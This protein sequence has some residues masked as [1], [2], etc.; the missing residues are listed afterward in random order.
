MQLDARCSSF[1]TANLNY[2][3]KWQNSFSRLLLF[4]VRSRQ[5]KSYGRFLDFFDK[6]RDALAA[7]DT[8]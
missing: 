7:A 3:Y 4:T 8:G 2:L 5:K 1:K 6:D